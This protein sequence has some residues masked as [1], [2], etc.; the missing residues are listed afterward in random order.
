MNTEVESPIDVPLRIMG[1][2]KRKQK[3][4]TH[5]TLTQRYFYFED[6]RALQTWSP[7]LI[8]DV[9]LW[10]SGA[11][12][13]KYNVRVP[14]SYAKKYQYMVNALVTTDASEVLTFINKELAK[15][16]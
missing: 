10:V 3:T 9:R 6:S 13:L 1:W 5:H 11:K 15:C 2:L 4:R 8:V 12:P 7:S 16:K 14:K